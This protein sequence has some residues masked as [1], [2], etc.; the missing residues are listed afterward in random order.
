MMDRMGPALTTQILLR[1]GK[2]L[3]AG[4]RAAPPELSDTANRPGCKCSGAITADLT[5]GAKNSF[6]MGSFSGR[7]LAGI[8]PL[9]SMI[10]GAL[11][12]SGQKATQNPAARNL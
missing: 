7:K 1:L 9:G 10:P 5:L 6:I 3:S 2:K 11:S 12:T 4:L 8:A